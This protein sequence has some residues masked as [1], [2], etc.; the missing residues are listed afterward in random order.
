MLQLAEVHFFIFFIFELWHLK[1]STWSVKKKKKNCLLFLNLFSFSLAV[2]S[3]SCT[4]PQNGVLPRCPCT[5]VPFM[6]R[7]V[8]TAV[9]PETLTVPGM[10]NTALLSPRLPR[11]QSAFIYPDR[12]S[13][14]LTVWEIS[15]LHYRPI[16]ILTHCQLIY[17]N[18]WI[19]FFNR[20]T[21]PLQNKEKSLCQ[22]ENSP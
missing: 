8:R 5:G 10:E 14:I 15:R 11:G 1:I 12:R 7:P 3:N 17:G 21:E 2:Y 22:S 18:I 9:W 4:C 6:A 16:F 13:M 19:L 20:S